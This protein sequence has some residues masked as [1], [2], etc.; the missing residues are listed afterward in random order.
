MWKDTGL[1]ESPYPFF[2]AFYDGDGVMKEASSNKAARLL[3]GKTVH[4]ANKLQGGASLRTVNSRLCGKRG[5][6]LGTIYGRTGAKIIDE[7]SQ[8]SAKLFHA[9]AF[10]TAMARAPIFRVRP[11][12]Y[13][14]REHTWGDLPI[15]IRGGDELQLPPVPMEASLLAP[16][17]GTSVVH[18]AGAGIFASLKHVYRL[19]TAMRFTNSVLISILEK[20]RTPGGMKLTNAEWSRLQATEKSAMLQSSLGRNTTMRLATLGMW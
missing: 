8:L 15:F 9:D 16:L 19:T 10:I 14:A 7:L 11:E 12:L 6:V 1:H 17:E 4:T 20:M 3:R 13:A 18:K 2:E 5:R